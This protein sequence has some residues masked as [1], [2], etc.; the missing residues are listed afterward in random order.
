MEHDSFDNPSKQNH[1]YIEKRLVK[2][3]GLLTSLYIA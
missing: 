1:E 3:H 2:S